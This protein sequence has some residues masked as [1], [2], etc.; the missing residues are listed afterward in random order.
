MSI[1]S[2]I[3]DHQL[4]II[5]F[6]FFLRELISLPLMLLPYAELAKTFRKDDPLPLWRQVLGKKSNASK[7]QWAKV[8]LLVVA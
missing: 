3:K 1:K 7:V 6:Q 4:E 8:S 5:P 2:E